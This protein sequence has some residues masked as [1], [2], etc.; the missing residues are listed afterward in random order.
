[1]KSIEERYKEYKQ[2]DPLF[3]D[4]LRAFLYAAQE[5]QELDEQEHN[6]VM[7]EQYKH[8]Q[9]QLEKQK[10]E[11]IEKAFKLFEGVY[12]DEHPLDPDEF[13]QAMEE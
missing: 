4:T 11:L 12:Y 13:K 3:G 8:F 6:N 7:N 5:Q 2:R 9:E 10:R 1:M